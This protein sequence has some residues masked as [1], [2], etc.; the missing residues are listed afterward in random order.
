[1]F[2]AFSRVTDSTTG[3][4]TT[5][6]NELLRLIRKAREEN[7]DLIALGGDIVNYPSPR[8]VSWVLQQLR[9][10]A[11]GIPFVY[12][13]GNHDWHLEATVQDDRYDSQRVPNLNSTLLPLITG[14]VATAPHAFGPGAGLLY[15]SARVKGVDI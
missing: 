5:P 12:T 9:E 14:S 2:E 13:S 3:E 10:A 8:T 1:M 15:G 6:R 4:P 7:V 11:G